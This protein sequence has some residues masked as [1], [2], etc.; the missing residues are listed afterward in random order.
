MTKML[1]A[2]RMGLGGPIGSGKQWFP[3]IHLTD[4][5]AAM[6]FLLDRSDADGPV[7]FC[8]PEPVRQGDFARCLGSCLNRPAVLPAP[9]T[10]MRLVLGEFAGTLLTSQRVIPERLQQMGFSFRFPNIHMALD[11]ITTHI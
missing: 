10:M 6:A 2:F 11:D 7:N 4:L 9:A 3:W 5:I 1:P 8:A